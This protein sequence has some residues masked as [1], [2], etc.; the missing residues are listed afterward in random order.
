MQ[1]PTTLPDET[2]F[3]RYIRHMTILG[4]NEKDYLKR[5]FNK[6]RASIHPYLTIGITKASQISKENAAKIYREQTLGRL[7]SYFLPHRSTNI[8]KALLAEDGNTAI[9]T[10]QL[11]SFKESETLSLKYC[12][13]CAK[14][15]MSF[16]GVSYWHLTHQVPGVEACPSHK[17]W[18]IHHKLPER[19]HLK[20]QLLPITSD[21]AQICS[22][23]S[24][25]FARFTDEFLRR[26]AVTNDSF[27]QKHLLKRI[28]ERGYTLG[29]KR[30]N[31]VELTSDL[32][33]FIKG[34]KH[35]DPNLLPFSEDDYRYLSYLLS[36][37]VS[38]HPFKYLIVD[39]WLNNTAKSVKAEL[40]EKMG[41]SEKVK[42]E[43]V[44]R[45][46]VKLLKQQESLAEISRCIGKS[47]CYVKSVA[48]KNN[49]PF[50][51]K[52]YI[53]TDNI[54]KQ[55]IILAYKGFHRKAIARHFHI[56]TGS[57]EQIISSEPGLVEKRR[58][59]KFES[60]R[61]RY[62]AQ[63]IRALQLKP[64]A[65]KQEIK[66]SCYAA[67]HWLYAHE[68][69]WLNSALPSST[70]PQV[71]SKINWEERDVKLASK[72]RVAMHNTSSSISLAELDKMLGGHG[73][74][75]QMQHKLPVTMAVFNK[76]EVE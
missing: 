43:N 61:R 22:E 69:N 58:R 49:I 29:E 27:D 37:E 5:L 1:L 53:L 9:R 74:L 12:P 23:L 35:N 44:A 59:Y 75:I 28:Q 33:N 52:P 54:V 13:I 19:P 39:F 60:K 56:S 41:T 68:R 46:C 3:S 21:E 42:N 73:W 30:F 55:I 8:Y 11:V 62:K 20:L 70:K 17:V 64:K 36:G 2:L 4:M 65:I 67:F 26:T 16:Y 18:L 24:Y 63:I 45:Q 51:K 15:D 7:F 57:V 66:S 32:F 34:L 47:R 71:R 72:V 48:L 25:E 50:Q 6:P 76:L 31:R 10:C 14:E 38:Q 40:A